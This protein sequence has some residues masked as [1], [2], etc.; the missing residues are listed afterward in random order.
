MFGRQWE[1]CSFLLVAVGSR[2]YSSVVWRTT[3]RRHWLDFEPATDCSRFVSYSCYYTNFTIGKKFRHFTEL[4]RG[5][6]GTEQLWFAWCQ[7]HCK[8]GAWFRLPE[9]RVTYSRICDG[10]GADSGVTGQ[11]IPP[12][13]DQMHGRRNFSGRPN[14]LTNENFAMFTWYQHRVLSL[15]PVATVVFCNLSLIFSRPSRSALERGRLANFGRL[16]VI[17]CVC[18]FE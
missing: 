18:I 11:I 12:P 17:C 3:V 8:L 15:W 9:T 7:C 13:P 1:K 4:H 5:T 6:D 2:A 10:F 16:E 14:N